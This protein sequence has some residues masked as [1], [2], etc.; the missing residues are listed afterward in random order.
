MCNVQKGL[1]CPSARGKILALRFALLCVKNDNRAA[2][3]WK[4]PLDTMSLTLIIG[5]MFAGKS[6]AILTRV[7]RAQVLGWKTF[8]ATCSLDNRYDASGAMVMTHDHAGIEA[9]GVKVLEGVRDREDYKSARLIVIEEGQF[10]PD[11]Y[12]FVLAAV[13]EDAKEVVVVGLD[14]DSDRKPFGR[15]LDLIPLADEVVR[16]TSLCKRCGDGTPAL[17]SALVKGTKQGQIH[18]GGADTYEPLCRK[19]YLKNKK[20]S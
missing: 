19:H 11:L 17:F 15:I 12:E 16:I 10:I 4:G 9:I 20:T 8:I 7:R 18:V 14:G 3:I 6:S 2:C 1:P 5:P 13:E